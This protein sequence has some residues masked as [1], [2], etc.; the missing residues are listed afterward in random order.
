MASNEF[1]CT[2]HVDTRELDAALEKA[3]QLVA[4]NDQLAPGRGAELVAAVTAGAF[5]EAFPRPV[6]RRG[7]LGLGW[8]RRRRDP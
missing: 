7:L 8:L 1:R 3:R 5:V 6:S 2:M 4:L